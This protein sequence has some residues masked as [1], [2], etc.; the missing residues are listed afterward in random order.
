[1]SEGDG[2]FKRVRLPR[3]GDE[4]IAWETKQNKE[5]GEVLVGGSRRFMVVKKAVLGIRGDKSEM[6]RVKKVGEFENFFAYGV[7]TLVEEGDDEPFVVNF[8]YQVGYKEAMTT[9][10]RAWE[11]GQT[12]VAT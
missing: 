6:G 2:A 8:E 3:W 10:P 11:A 4:R 9:W 7:Y 1:M 12:G 5:V